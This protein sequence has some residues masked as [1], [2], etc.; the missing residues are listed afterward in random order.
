[1]VFKTF[2]KPATSEIVEKELLL[3]HIGSSMANPQIKTNRKKM[4]TAYFQS[5]KVKIGLWQWFEGIIL[6]KLVFSLF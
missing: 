3:L 6:I 2:I 5:K 1:M 4:L